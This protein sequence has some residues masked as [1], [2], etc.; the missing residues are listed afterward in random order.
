MPSENVI[1]KKIIKGWVVDLQDDLK[2]IRTI[3]LI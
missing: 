3:V 2:A 1:D